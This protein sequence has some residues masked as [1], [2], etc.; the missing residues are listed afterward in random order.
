MSDPA[1][2]FG[3]IEQGRD[4]VLSSDR[5]GARLNA[6][7]VALAQTE[8]D[9]LLL[10]GPENLF[11]ACGRQTAGYFA[12]Q[13]LIIPRTGYPV[14][15]VREL[16]GPGARASTWIKDIRTFGD[17]DNPAAIVRDL[18]IEKGITDLAVEQAAWFVSAEMSAIIAGQLRT[19]DVTIRDG[20]GLVEAL[21]VVKSNWELTAIRKAAS[22]AEAGMQAALDVCAAGVSENDVA[23]AMLSAAVAA[24]SE[25]MGMEP[26]VSS[27][28]RAGVP[29]ATWRRRHLQS[30]DPVFL[31][32]AGSHDR[33]HAA[34]M[35]SVWIG[36]PPT[37]VR[38]MM[39]CTKRALDA[40]LGVLSPGRPCADAHLAAV[41]VISD[42]GYLPAL[43][44][45]IGY[46]MG[47]AFAPDWGEGAILSLNASES[48]LV[49]PGMVFHLPVTLRAFGQWTVGVSETVI[50]GTN[51]PEPLSSLGRDLSI[52]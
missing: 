49:E 47:I 51:T 18:V 14:L 39:D 41:R 1:S 17:L 26:L 20:T 21:R 40:A 19:S 34:L 24:G 32:L 52:R 16:E 10:N 36:A 35:R 29:H 30:G 13:A 50:V 11:W 4:S 43:R 45:R 15:L 12:Y 25:S 38:R 8:A 28:P 7:Q 31:E 33:Y 23:A 42:A 37:E 44:K 5:A 9:A 48:R 6:I 46:S 2:V 22:Y 3:D 27:G